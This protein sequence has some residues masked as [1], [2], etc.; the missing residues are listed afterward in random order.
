M[1]VEGD[2]GGNALPLTEHEKVMQTLKEIDMDEDTYFQLRR[3]SVVEHLPRLAY[4]ISDILIYVS[5]SDFSS[6][7]YYDTVQEVAINSATRGVL[8]SERPSLILIC[9]KSGLTKT[10]DVEKTT[11][12]FFDLHDK[13]RTLLQTYLDVKCIRIPDMHK[14][15]IIKKDG[16]KI[17]CETVF[18]Q[19]INE[20]YKTISKL[21]KGRKKY[22]EKLGN[23]YSEWIW[24][25]LFDLTLSKFNFSAGLRMGS[26]LSEA[27]MASD[28][29]LSKAVRFF[30]LINLKPF[31]QQHYIEKRKHA[32][33]MLACFILKEML[34]LVPELKTVIFSQM[35]MKEKREE[36]KR[37]LYQFIQ[38]LERLQP[39]QALYEEKIPCTDVKCTHKPNHHCNSHPKTYNTSGSPVW[40]RG[41]VQIERELSHE[42]EGQF[43]FKDTESLD[44]LEKHFFSV[45]DVLFNVI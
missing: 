22:R 8:N 4:V 16:T 34:D 13:K 33:R 20:L 10:F 19:Q 30:N 5:S 32:I 28:D 27:L 11:K 3:E 12:N 14:K 38:Q 29:I 31:S 39:C 15:D 7:S 24:C 18:S 25:Q 44:D 45:F 17:R 2:S 1:D 9:N 35:R 26:I 6:H 43:V 21:L 23:L 36:A 41:N 42:W 40:I 37:L